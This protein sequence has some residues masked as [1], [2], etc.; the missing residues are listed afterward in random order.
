L[1]VV[2]PSF[3]CAVCAASGQIALQL[4]SC[5]AVGG[6]VV[7]KIAAADAMDWIRRRRVEVEGKRESA[8]QE[9]ESKVGS[10]IEL[11]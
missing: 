2:A 5:G 4:A 6:V 9:N 8:G 1:T 10:E 3:A 11:I 7:A